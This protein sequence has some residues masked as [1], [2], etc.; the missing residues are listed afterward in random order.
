M[1]I[2]IPERRPQME[3]QHHHHIPISPRCMLIDLADSES[4]VTRHGSMDSSLC[5]LRAVD[6]SALQGRSNSDPSK[7][8]KYFI[9]IR[10]YWIIGREHLHLVHLVLKK[11]HN[12]DSSYLNH[13]DWE[14]NRKRIKQNR[15]IA[16][17]R[18]SLGLAA[19]A[20]T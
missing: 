6:T 17:G 3:L 13:K 4:R 15:P 1:F 19:T 18:L 9:E 7:H 8:S 12:Y 2:A 14:K 20:R 16:A 5:Q 10:S 11:Q